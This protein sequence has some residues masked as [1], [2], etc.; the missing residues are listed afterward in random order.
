MTLII[1]IGTIPSYLHF[2]EKEDM[3]KGYI[4]LSSVLQYIA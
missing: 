3:N 4:E 1:E 2:P